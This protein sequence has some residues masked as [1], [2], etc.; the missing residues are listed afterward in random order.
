MFIGVSLKCLSQENNINLSVIL[1]NTGMEEL[2]L[3][4][5]EKIQ[6]KL[7]TMV[8]NHGIAGDSYFVLFPKYEIYNETLVEGLQNL[9]VLDIEFSM[10]IKEIQT[11]RI[12]GSLTQKIQAQGTTKRRA[13]DKSI[14]KI[15]T[16]GNEIESFLAKTK[17]EIMDYYTSNCNQINSEANSLMQQKRFRE[18]IAL[19]YAVPKSTGS[20]CYNKIQSKLNEAYL[21]Y[22]NATCEEN[23]I[24]AKN[25]IKN[26]NNHSA[27]EVLEEI[28]PESNCYKEAQQLSL[29]INGDLNKKTSVKKTE[30]AVTGGIETTTSTKKTDKSGKTISLVRKSKKVEAIAK[31]QYRSRH[32]KFITDNN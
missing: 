6:R 15:K 23:I 22:M 12:Y 14:S 7:Y 25:A 20:G 24:R 1:T 18:A 3:T 29:E 19:L 32:E 2:S 28:D 16:S 5:K 30:I 21:G 17:T 8:T 13:I 26:N 11:G 10:F 31:V 4:Q 27:L 9:T